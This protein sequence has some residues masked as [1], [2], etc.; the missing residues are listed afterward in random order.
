ML[1]KFLS[2][3][4]FLNFLVRGFAACGII[5]AHLLVTFNSFRCQESCDPVCCLLYVTVLRHFAQDARFNRGNG[6]FLVHMCINSSLLHGV[7]F[8]G[9]MLFTGQALAW[10]TLCNL[11]LRKC[12]SDE[13][14]VSSNPFIILGSCGFVYCLRSR[15]RNHENIFSIV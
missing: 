12:R 15:L 9:R 10:I 1:L 7:L 3:Y 13:Q 11:P 5:P 8:A 4:H 2:T 6:D 14:S